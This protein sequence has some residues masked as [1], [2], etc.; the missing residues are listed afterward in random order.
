MLHQIIVILL[1]REKVLSS[2][3]GVLVAAGDVWAQKLN[4]MKLLDL[5]LFEVT[6]HAAKR[7]HLFR[8]N[9]CSTCL[10]DAIRRPGVEIDLGMSQPALA[11]VEHHDT[12]SFFLHFN[13][14]EP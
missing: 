1:K 10:S 2:K 13:Y 14:L 7:W 3:H 11:F 12:F 9:L 6:A 8:C 4:G 5:F